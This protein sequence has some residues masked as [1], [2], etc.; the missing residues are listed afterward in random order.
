M[1][2]LSVLLLAATLVAVLQAVFLRAALREVRRLEDVITWNI[3]WL[4]A[5]RDKGKVFEFPPTAM[6]LTRDANLVGFLR[7]ARR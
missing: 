3:D 5:E 2:L 4:I 6:H 7:G 1:I